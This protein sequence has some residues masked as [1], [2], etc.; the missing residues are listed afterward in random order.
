MS[1]TKRRARPAAV[2]PSA[3][4][5]GLAVIAHDGADPST[6]R[7]TLIL[8]VALF[9]L[10]VAVLIYW[11]RDVPYRVG[12]D[13][14]VYLRYAKSVSHAGPGSLPSLTRSYLQGADPG[15]WPPPTRVG[16]VLPAA[17]F[18]RVTEN[19]TPLPLTYLSTCM[20]LASI[21]TIFWFVRRNGSPTLALVTA[22]FV[23]CSPLLMGLSRRA[24]TDSTIAF[25]TFALL[26]SFY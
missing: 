14:G 7:N 3:P 19:G 16:F 17:V 25:L 12:A 23:A 15:T 1:R 8:F 13:E 26:A 9:A 22:L 5:G 18:M 10:S 4:A 2:Q 11:V 20:F 6:R 24:L 21:V